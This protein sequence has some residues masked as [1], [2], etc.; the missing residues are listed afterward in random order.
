[1]RQIRNLIA[2][3]VLLITMSALAAG[4][5]VI[6]VVTAVPALNASPSGSVVL[7][8]YNT[9]EIT[10]RV[11]GGS[12]NLHLLRKIQLTPTSFQ[13][14]PWAEDRSVDVSQIPSDANGYFSARFT[15][16]ANDPIDE[17]LVLNPAGSVTL[18][19]TI[20][21]VIRGVNY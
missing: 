21:L 7:K 11:S 6:G 12:G 20:P 1:M 17:F 14:R 18:D 5:Q 4:F 9:I 16:P 15:M 2:C 8:G 13:F 10:G 3:A 19:G